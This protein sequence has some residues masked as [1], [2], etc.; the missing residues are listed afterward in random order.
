[1]W[2]GNAVGLARLENRGDPLLRIYVISTPCCPTR[3][4]R[5][6]TN[7]DLRK[8]RPRR[9][10]EHE[11][12]RCVV[13][14]GVMGK[15]GLLTAGG[16]STREA[17]STS[18]LPHGSLHQGPACGAARVCEAPTYRTQA[19]SRSHTHSASFRCPR[20]RDGLSVHSPSYVKSGGGLGCFVRS[21]ATPRCFG[22]RSCLS[23]SVSSP[24]YKPEPLSQKPPPHYVVR[25][26]KRREGACRLP[27]SAA[28]TAPPFNPPLASCTSIA[29]SPV[30][31]PLH[32]PAHLCGRGS[33]RL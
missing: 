11:L 16:H 14:L 31:P 17:G 4:R 22:G 20:L 2:P 29:P 13:V 32:A 6:P 28:L 12:A 26:P 27:T 8:P 9:K 25:R 10:K 21:C 33:A 15:L 23:L 1:M 3:P 19:T 5:F 24:L 7:L 30:S 18:S